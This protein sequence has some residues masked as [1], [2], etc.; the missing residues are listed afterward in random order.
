MCLAYF[1]YAMIHPT[2]HGLI[3]RWSETAHCSTARA[4]LFQ[5]RESQL[6]TKYKTPVTTLT[7][8]PPLPLTL[9][10]ISQT[11]HHHVL[12]Q[13]QSYGYDV[14]VDSV[15]CYD[16]HHHSSFYRWIGQHRDP[17]RDQQPGTAGGRQI[18]ERPDGIG[19]T[20]RTGRTGITGRNTYQVS[21]KF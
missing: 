21:N 17:Q 12:G 18:T 11:I 9:T 3:M 6:G 4:V 5:L 20:G 19:W 10:L 15:S 14:T 2:Q 8:P 16:H 1:V 13:T 7:Q